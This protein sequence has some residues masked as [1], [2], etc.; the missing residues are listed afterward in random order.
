MMSIVYVRWLRSEIVK[1]KLRANSPFTFNLFP[2]LSQAAGGNRPPGLFH[3]FRRAKTFSQH[4]I[5]TMAPSLRGGFSL[6]P[7]NAASVA[8]RFA[9]SSLPLTKGTASLKS[10]LLLLSRVADSLSPRTSDRYRS[11][12][13]GLHS[14]ATPMS[15]SNGLRLL[16]A[17]AFPKA[18]HY[19]SP[20]HSKFA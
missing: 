10:E 13:Q 18:T 17:A 16:T 6:P 3:F 19:Q 2:L 11:H 9:L 1:L 7:S 8:V 14:C 12:M 4:D 15:P 20:N 5:T